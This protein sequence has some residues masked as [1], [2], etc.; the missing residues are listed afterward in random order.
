V[1]EL[2]PGIH[3]LGG[4]KGGHVRAF[5]LESG[6]E[7]TLVDT[8]FEDDAAQVLEA[9]DRL[10]R[11]PGDLKRIALT[12]AH[13]SHLGGVAALRRA[14]GATVL[15]H[16]WE[17][18]I[19]SGDRPAQSVG[20]KPTRPFKTYPFQVGIF[21]NRPRHA[22]CPV[23]EGLEDGD[24]AGP[25]QVLHLPGHSPGHLGF[26]WPERGFLIAGDAIATWPRFEGGWRAFTINPA[27]HAVSLRRMAE[28][29]APLVGVGHGDAITVDAVDRLHDL[30]EKTASR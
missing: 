25:L 29:E 18:D 15:G 11:K 10:G 28:L 4:R 8:L 12:H 14:T 20:L 27:Q 7:L 6:N 9:I 19:V 17:A 2:A 26:Y 30:V 24:Q 13:R 1:R 22:P 3:S 21:L 23:D 5:L 16:A